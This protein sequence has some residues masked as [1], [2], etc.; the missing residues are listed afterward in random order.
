MAV[1]A[2]AVF[3]ADHANHRIRRID[4][5]GTLTTIA[6][7][8]LRGFAGDGA[9]AVRARLGFPSALAV[10]P[11]GA[12][13]VADEM[14]HRIRRIDP[15]GVIDTVAGDG[16]PHRRRRRGRR[17]R[18]RRRSRRPRPAGRAVRRGRGRRRIGV[19]RGGGRSQGAQDRRRR[20][21]QHGR[22]G[23]RPV[24]RLRCGRRR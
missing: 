4:G 5:S 11:D 21:H 8:G 23:V 14:N 24:R 13:L 19:H 17:R 18:G 10:A 7:D 22:R 6:G 9:G 1:G 20:C 3:V 16:S 15:S 12:V 2:G